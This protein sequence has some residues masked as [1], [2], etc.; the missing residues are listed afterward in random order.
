MDLE[1]DR[2]ELNGKERLFKRFCWG[3]K[4]EFYLWMSYIL[5]M[6]LERD[7]VSNGCGDIYSVNV[8]MGV[9]RF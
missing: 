8:D 7:F 9:L 1:G 6:F 3:N 2:R 4:S 5:R